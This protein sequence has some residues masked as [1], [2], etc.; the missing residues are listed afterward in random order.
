MTVKGRGEDTLLGQ[1]VSASK[2]LVMD[3]DLR[4]FHNT[5]DGF[6][7]VPD[8]RR[9]SIRDRFYGA[10]LGWIGRNPFLSW[11]LDQMGHLKTDLRS[12]TT[13][14]RIGLEIGGEKTAAYL[15]DSRFMRLPAAFE[16]SFAGLPDA[17]DRYERLIQGWGVLLGAIG[18]DRPPTELEDSEVSELR[19][20]S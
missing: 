19:L 6:P 14:Q 17:I 16:A 20:A 8:I 4:I 7:D 3:V 11:Y 18:R 10:C 1:A 13:L 15:Q 2:G 5:Y 12:E 9:K